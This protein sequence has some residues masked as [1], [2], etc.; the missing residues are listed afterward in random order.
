MEWL[1]IIAFIV[2]TIL[3]S[4]KKSD[5]A[6]QKRE[7]RQQT[8]GQPVYRSGETAAKPQ[9]QSRPAGKPSMSSAKPQTSAQMRP[10]AQPKPSAE[11][12]PEGPWYESFG[13]FVKDLG[14]EFKNIGEELS[15]EFTLESDQ[16]PKK[17]PTAA[18]AGK[19][20]QK[21]AKTVKPG[22]AKAEQS[23]PGAKKSP[24]DLPTK[25]LMEQ[26]PDREQRA[27]H[28]K[29]TATVKPVTAS[30]KPLKNA[31]ENDEH[32]EHRIELNPNIQYSN[33]KQQTDLQHAA[34]VK[35]DPESVISGVIWSE[36]LGKPRAHQ[37]IE[38]RFRRR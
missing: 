18:S 22:K 7:Q 16:I 27:E 36:I 32:C 23:V 28:T 17:Q 35:T 34:I 9:A 38:H 21:P 26:R 8:M 4:K 6:K 33:R 5:E 31:F 12:Q 10:Q 11:K 13:E 19:P 37:P 30:V 14:S 3:D 29:V 20:A 15:K 1:M 2:I 25:T 24:A